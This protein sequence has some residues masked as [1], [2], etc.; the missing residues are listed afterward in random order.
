MYV[1]PKEASAYYKVS[2]NTLRTWANEGRIQCIKTKGGHR[3]YFLEPREQEQLKEQLREQLK[4]SREKRIIYARVSSRKQKDDLIRQTK[5]LSQKYPTYNLVTDI[6]SG[7][8]FNRKSFKRIL[9]DLFKGNIR[10]VVVT[11]KDRFSRFGYNLFEWI[12]QQHGAKLVCDKETTE[13]ETEEL[14][15]DLMAIITAFTARYHG[16]RKYKTTGLL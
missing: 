2:E 8:N 16:R 6:G 5:Y 13:S 15:E 3:R 9:E 12:F 10:E 7:I 1:E 4:E 14:S 11:H